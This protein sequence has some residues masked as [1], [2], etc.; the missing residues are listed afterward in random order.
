MHKI[1]GLLFW[2]FLRGTTVRILPDIISCTLQVPHVVHPIFSQLSA[3]TLLPD[4]LVWSTLFNYPLGGGPTVIRTVSFPTD[5]RILLRIMCTNLQ[6][7]SHTSS[8]P[9]EKAMFLNALLHVDSINLPTF[10]CHHILRMQSPRSQ[11]RSLLC[12]FDSS[13]YYFFGGHFS[14]RGFRT[15]QSTYRS[16]YCILELITCPFVLFF[17]RAGRA[18]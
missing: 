6:P 12:L 10:I 16:G 9:T 3:E 14:R 17:H 1:N 8:L 15:C 4:Y 5:Y 18:C 2:L 13:S 7:V 11:N